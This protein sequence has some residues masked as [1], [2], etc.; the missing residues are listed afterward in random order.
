MHKRSASTY[1]F[2][3]DSFAE[4]LTGPSP[5]D[6]VDGEKR[7][8]ITEP[9]P[10]RKKKVKENVTENTVPA[11]G[12]NPSCALRIQS[13]F[14]N[15]AKSSYFEF[16]II[17]CIMINTI[18]MASEHTTMS[19]TQINISKIANFVSRVNNLSFFLFFYLANHYLLTVRLT[20]ARCNKGMFFHLVP[21][22]IFIN[23]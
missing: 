8:T 14:Y 19:K 15:L 11:I 12:E 20:G 3:G 4:F 13:V 9:P 16:S 1:S 6:V 10:K 18:I 2:K 23:Q 21:N 5:I 17:F 22:L 7:Y